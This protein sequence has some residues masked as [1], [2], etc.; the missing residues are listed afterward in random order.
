MH[1]CKQA[2]MLAVIIPDIIIIITGCNLNS[3]TCSDNYHCF[4]K[5]I[6]NLRFDSTLANV[7]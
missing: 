5:L 7:F 4:R 1:T 2:I 3:V 6:N